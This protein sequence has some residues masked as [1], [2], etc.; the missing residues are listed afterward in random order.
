M[1]EITRVPLQPIG[2]G[3]LP[4]LW[5]GIVIA[6]LL[7]AGAAWATRYQGLEVTTLSEGTG[8]SPTI[9]DIVNVN[10]EG[11]L[12]D[13][14]V[15]DSAEGA[16]FPVAGVVPGFS[17]ALQQMQRG[18]RYEVFIPSDQAYGAEGAGDRIPPNADLTFTVELVDFRSE[19]ELRAIQQ[20]MQ[21][22]GLGGM[23][24]APGGAAAGN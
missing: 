7:A 11:K 18:G 8:G 23:G 9:D 20:Q 21:Q 4:K 10:Y 24:G 1:A 16:I 13:G 14:T 17:T 5:I 19:A 15:F 3:I 12:P 2:K 22:M 6:V